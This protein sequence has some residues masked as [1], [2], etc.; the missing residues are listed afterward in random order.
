MA[1]IIDLDDNDKPREKAER[2][3]I[4]AL[5]DEELL[6]LIIS[7]GT[8]GHS[9]LDIARD[10]LKDNKYLW[11]LSRLISCLYLCRLLPPGFPGASALW[12]AEHRRR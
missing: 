10:L 11:N 4:E 2:F 7:S 6:A 5:K 8:V 12:S 1:R 3:G 9:S